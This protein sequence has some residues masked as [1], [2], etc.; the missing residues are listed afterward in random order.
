MA[1]PPGPVAMPL[2]V[3]VTGPG[4]MASKSTDASTPVPDAPVASAPRASV[5]SIRL[6]FT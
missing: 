3:I 1:A 2:I 4:A 6:P 5:I